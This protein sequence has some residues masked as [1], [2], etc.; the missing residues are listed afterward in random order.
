MTAKPTP[1]PDVTDVLIDV[2]ETLTQ[3]IA[4][5]APDETLIYCNHAYA[6]Q[7]PEMAD[8][9][10]PGMDW[11][12]FIQACLD[13]DKVL[14]I[15]GENFD[16]D[17]ECD[18]LRATSEPKRVQRRVSGRVFDLSY[19]PMPNGGFVITREDVTEKARAEEQAADRAALLTTILE[20]NP[21][22][23]VMARL[24]D[25]K[26]VWQSPAASDLVGE[27][28][29]ALDYFNDPSRRAEYTAQLQEHGRVEDFRT[30]ANAP[31]GS[32]IAVALSGMLTEFEGETCVVSSITDLTE[33]QYR[34]GLLTKMI[35][36][37]PA[38]V[39]MNRAASGEI[40]YRSPELVALLGDGLNA[41]SFYADPGD[42]QGFLAALRKD[43]TVVDRRERLVN[44]AGNPFWAAVSGRLTE[45]NGEEVLVTFTRDL[46][47]Q[48]NMEAELDRQRELTFENEKMSALGGLL[49]GV[50]HELNNPLSVVVGHAMMLQE[51]SLS[52]D[53][54]RQVQK[55]SD[56][57]ERCARIVKTFLSMA[58]QE[59]ARVDPVDLNELIQIAAEVARYGDDAHSVQI[60]MSLAD[61]MP[62]IEGD[63]D[64]LTQLAI[65]LILNAEQAIAASGKGDRVVLTTARG[66]D[67]ATL[68]VEDNGP[69]VPADVRKR[70]FEPLFTTK[71][72]GQGTGLG[73]SMCHRIAA[74]HGGVI[75]VEDVDGGGARFVVE[76]PLSAKSL[77]MTPEDSPKTDTSETAGRVLVIDDEQDVAELNAEVLN[78]AGYETT[79]VASAAEGLDLLARET[80]DIV[81]S[82]LNMPG[83]DG[84]AFFE[85]VRQ[86]YPDLVASVGF[87]T[88]DTLG[89]SSQTFLAE[90]GRPYLE[91]PV[92][93]KELRAFVD[94]LRQEARA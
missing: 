56:A 43:G 7:F 1:S 30:L 35:E 5:Y 55:I 66:A 74:S 4:I 88:G 39:L 57:A 17:T 27:K 23:V 91:K 92:S 78:R 21:I 68:S 36:A 61:D 29:F 10:R 67:H 11:R 32:V 15:L 22:P 18:A 77:T 73:L 79:A 94:D 26:V 44:A 40:L 71:G 60:R 59:P 72:V 2:S 50:A 54:H 45:W 3:G 46:S 69:G 82:D 19:S 24:T 89:R 12:A 33:L 47:P 70:I 90:A 63:A 48:L 16:V 37:C 14:A 34:E 20:T 25:S 93:P 76:L 75:R 31:D 9:L 87:I 85:A 64:Q 41:R 83:V 81:L 13:H 28:E 49:A 62:L 53:T 86:D 42:R 80:F 52:D 38:P 65:N 8:M 51:E 84:R 58:R 6:A